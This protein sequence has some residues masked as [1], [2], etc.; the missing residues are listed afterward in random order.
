[1]QR[2]GDSDIAESVMLAM[3]ERNV[4]VLPIHDSFIVRSGFALLL[5]EQMEDAYEERVGAKLD[6]KTVLSSFGGHQ[7]GEILSKFE[8]FH[9]VLKR[10]SEAEKSQYAGYYQRRRDFVAKKDREYFGRFEFQ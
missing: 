8:Q 2:V 4:L 9:E 10:Q 1:V 5:Q 6:I 3:M 7:D